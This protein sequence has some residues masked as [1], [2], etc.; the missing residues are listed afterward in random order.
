MQAERLRIESLTHH[1]MG[2][3]S[4]GS[5]W[6]RTLP[7][8]EIDPEGRILTPAPERVAAPC[9]HF[10]SCGGC[11]VQHARDD[12]VAAWK[13][14]I[15]TRALAAQGIT[16]VP[17]RIH[18]S[19]PASRRRAKFSARRTKKGAL[20]GFHARAS[21]TIV[22]VPD[23]VVLDP[24][25][26]ALIPAL[27]NLTAALASRKGEAGL[28]VTTSAAGADIHVAGVRAPTPQ[29][30]ID[31]AAWAER[32]DIARLTIGDETIVTRRPPEQP[33]GPARVIP[34]PGGFLQAT[35]PGET[36]LMAGLREALT[37]TTKIADLFAGCG[38]FSL[39]LAEMAEIH[40]VETLAAPLEALD[41]AWRRTPGLRPVTTETRDL[42]RRPLEHDELTHFDGIALDP[43]RAGAEAQIARI[44]PHGPARV[45]YVSCHPASFARDAAQLIAHGYRLD[46]LD[47]VDQFRWSAHVEL[48][49]AFSR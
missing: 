13:T 4:D 42:F 21:D 22:A 19:P 18:T 39:P 23:C 2:R 38:T 3:A 16:A 31:C 36:A 29:D 27:E 10:R 43:P 24:K 15:V 46:W 25:L 9:R 20:V 7:G 17:R 34:P 8:E 32:H 11:V 41:A 5:L 33:F 35:R 40:A 1:G 44:A 45:G 14:V 30:R 6:P 48:V 47:I 26:T 28:T 12:L 37:G 49:A